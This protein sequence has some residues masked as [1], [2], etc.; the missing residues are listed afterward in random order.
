MYFKVATGLAIFLQFIAFKETYSVSH[1][2]DM[3]YKQAGRKIHI[4]VNYKTPLLLCLEYR[5]LHS[6]KHKP[7]KQ[8]TYT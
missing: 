7:G 2:N 1:S 6:R 4:F 8:M 5:E 3:T